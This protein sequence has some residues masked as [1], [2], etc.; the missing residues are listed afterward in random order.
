MGQAK[1][2][3][4]SPQRSKKV[5]PL[6]SQMIK[7]Q[8]H[9][10][11]TLVLLAALS[12]AP[13][14]ANTVDILLSVVEYNKECR[15]NEELSANKTISEDRS[16]LKQIPFHG[17]GDAL[18][19]SPIHC[20]SI[21]FIGWGEISLTKKLARTALTLHEEQPCLSYEHILWIE[22]LNTFPHQS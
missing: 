7:A 1:K 15:L 5:V 2:L 6:Y 10:K 16:E 13:I 21:L 14:Q 22:T 9:I 17:T 12:G 20:N 4:I 18:F 8:L 11:L 19:I 3:F